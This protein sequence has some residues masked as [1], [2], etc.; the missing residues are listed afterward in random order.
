MP[1]GVAPK[2]VSEK[3]SRYTGVSQLQLRVSRYT[4]Q[5][6][7]AMPPVRLGLSGRNSGN[8]PGRPRK[9]SQSVSWNF[10]REYGWDAPKTY[11]S[12][13]LRLPERF[14]NF[15]PPQYGWGR[16]FFENWFRR[17][18]LRAGHGIPSSTGG[19]SDKVPGWETSFSFFCLRAWRA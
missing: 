2:F 18:P 11:N 3:V 16:L 15:L 8:I 7:W 9:R 12:R 19:I 10:P 1:G 6:R 5:L 13:H 17:G 4:V 14:Q